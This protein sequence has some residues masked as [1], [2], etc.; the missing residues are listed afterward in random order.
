MW[1][2]WRGASTREPVPQEKQHTRAELAAIGSQ[3][4]VATA[5]R[6]KIRDSF[7]LANTST[8]RALPAESRTDSVTQSYGH[9]CT[10]STTFRGTQGRI[11]ANNRF[12]AIRI[13]RFRTDIY[14]VWIDGLLKLGEIAVPVLM[15]DRCNWA[16]AG[17]SLTTRLY[18]CDFAG[19]IIPTLP[20]MLSA[21]PVFRKWEVQRLSPAHSD[22]WAFA[23]E[24]DVAKESP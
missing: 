17:A 11:S 18:A 7:D 3:A 21:E 24:R 12:A 19:T 13:S 4:A 14:C 5:S 22:G 2:Q 10:G 1:Q 9:C 6:R 23:I 20:V 8:S 15:S 16:F